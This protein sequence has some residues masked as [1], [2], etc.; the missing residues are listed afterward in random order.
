M[1]R[2]TIAQRLWLGLGILLALFG[3]ADLVSLRATHILDETLSNLVG[4]GET[5]NATAYELN[6]HLDAMNRAIESYVQERIPQ[7]RERRQNRK[8]SSSAA[9]PTT[10]RWRPPSAAAHSRNKL[11][12]AIRATSGQAQ[13]LMRLKDSQAS[14]LTAYDAHLRSVQSLVKQMPQVVWAS[15]E[16][17]PIAKRLSA[18]NLTAN[19]LT[20]AKGFRGHIPDLSGELEQ[21]IV[22]DQRAFSLVLA[23][24]QAL[25]QTAAERDWALEVEQWHARGTKQLSAMINADTARQRGLG[26]LARLRRSLENLLEGGIAPAQKAELKAAMDRASGTAHEANVLITRGLLLALVLGVLIALATGR[27]VK[28][29]LRALVA[30]SR[31][32][33]EGDFS[34]RVPPLARDE[35]GEL[36]GAFNEMAQ[37]LEATTVSRSY[38]ESVVNS[39]GEALL[40]ISEG[41]VKTANPVAEQLLGYEAGALI[42]KSLESLLASAAHGLDQNWTNVPSRFRSDFVTREG[43][44]IP[45]F[46]P[47]CRWALTAPRVRPS[48]VSRKTCANGSQRNGINDKPRWF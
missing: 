24:Y 6:G 18:E 31:K 43:V 32:F 33:A 13:E 41:N 1:F 16:A 36:T 15:R 4:D 21:D 11:P 42:G 3:A 23:R 19:L 37:K 26:N 29:P 12:T 8:P 39:M 40:V 25:A 44:S 27:A 9:S 10:G 47:L 46:V 34:H 45:V 28:A 2:L 14:S 17:P 7:Q 35:I 5:R 22:E 48:C 20:Q 38:M 30:S